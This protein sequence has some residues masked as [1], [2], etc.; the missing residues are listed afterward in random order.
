MG[1]CVPSYDL[2]WI[3]SSCIFFVQADKMRSATDAELRVTVDLDE[4]AKRCQACVGNRPVI[5]LGSGASMAH[6][7]RGMG[8]LASHLKEKIEPLGA[9]EAAAWLL[10]RSALN[11]GEHLEA[12]LEQHGV[13]DALLHRVVEETW[14]FVSEDDR[15]ILLEIVERELVLPVAKLYQGLLRSTAKKLHVV[16]TNYDRLAEYAANSVGLIDDTG[17]I[18]GYCRVEFQPGLYS[19]KKGRHPLST[20]SVWKVHGSLDW[21][22][23]RRDQFVSLSSVHDVPIGFSP[24]IVTP[25]VSKYQ[26]THKDPFR[27]TI[28]GADAALDAA[29]AYV[30]IGYGFRDEHIHPKLQA[31]CRDKNTPIIVAARTLTSEAKTF[32]CDCGG[33]NFIGLED[34]ENGTKV[35]LPEA[36][37][38]FILDGKKIWEL[39]NLN[40]IVG[41]R[42]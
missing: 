27:S 5:V 34:H 7:V 23:N 13:P 12:A 20:V 1:V 26:K 39:K 2:C 6:G 4:V 29:E 41:F 15:K 25:G 33:R 14:N 9:E 3:I 31:R 32:L 35:Y 42:G 17:F 8:D 18:P 36:P 19:F 21:F 37:E 40:E 11:A 28:Q 38:G 16:T 30:C 24:L 10:V 22:A